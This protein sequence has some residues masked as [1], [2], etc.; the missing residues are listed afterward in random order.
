MIA[1]LSVK[2]FLMFYKLMFQYAN[3][4]Q[5]HPSDDSFLLELTGY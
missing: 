2:L 1:S 3:D 5:C 4:L